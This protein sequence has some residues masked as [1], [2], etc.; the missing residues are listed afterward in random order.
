[1]ISQRDTLRRSPSQAGFTLVEL[2]VV[3]SIIALVLAVM[4]SAYNQIVANIIRK[5]VRTTLATLE[6]GCKRYKSDLCGGGKYPPGGSANLFKYLTGKGM[7]MEVPNGGFQLIKGGRVYGPYVELEPKS[8]D[9]NTLTIKDAYSNKI[10]YCVQTGT[11][12]EGEGQG[13]DTPP[14][15]Y[16]KRT[17]GNDPEVDMYCASPGPDGKYAPRAWGVI[18]DIVTFVSE[19]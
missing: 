17:S 19:E 11:T 18:D 10:A 12:F 2:L 16:C 14:A 1:M 6:A 9:A 15:G 5:Q 8:I 4:N 7:P 3:I 13:P